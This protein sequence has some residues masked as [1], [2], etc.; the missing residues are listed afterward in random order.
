[1]LNILAFVLILK[2]LQLQALPEENYIMSGGPSDSDDVVPYFYVEARSPSDSRHG[3]T[4]RRSTL[5]KNFARFGRGDISPLQ[6]SEYEWE[7][8]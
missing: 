4:S 3:E 2:A 5:E 7:D 8:G 6:G 1:M